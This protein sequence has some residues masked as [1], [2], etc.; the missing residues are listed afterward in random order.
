M[1]ADEQILVCAVRYAL[2]RRT[3]IVGVVCDYV[4]AKIRTLS[5]HCIIILIRDIE[6][7]M[8]RCHRLGYTLG[9]DCDEREWIKLLEVLKKE[10]ED[11]ER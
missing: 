5:K 8:E 2:G 7:E 9:D 11:A 3:Y 1:N 10:T 6:E 4:K